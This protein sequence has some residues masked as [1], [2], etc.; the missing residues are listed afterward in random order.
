MP[1]WEPRVDLQSLK[2]RNCPV[3]KTPA[4]FNNDF[5][6]ITSGQRLRTAMQSNSANSSTVRAFFLDRN[7]SMRVMLASVAGS[8]GQIEGY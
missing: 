7:C 8:L 6:C 5:D 2:C 4:T 1:V 3:I